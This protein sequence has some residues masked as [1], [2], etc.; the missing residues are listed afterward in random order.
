MPEGDKSLL[1]SGLGF[2]IPSDKF[3][4]SYYLL[5]FELIYCDIKGL[6]LPNEIT[7]FL[8][9]KVKDCEKPPF[10]I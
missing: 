3:E 7:N 6:H 4:Y 5:L 1:C 2:E 10:L 8:K 9:A